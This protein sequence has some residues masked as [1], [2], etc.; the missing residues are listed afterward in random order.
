MGKIY[1]VQLMERPSPGWGTKC[2]HLADHNFAHDKSNWNRLQR[3]KAS[4]IFYAKQDKYKKCLAEQAERSRTRTG[5]E[6]GA[7][8]AASA[9]E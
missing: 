6:A 5:V 7:A 3:R 8:A 1:Y 4:Q 9:V 2:R